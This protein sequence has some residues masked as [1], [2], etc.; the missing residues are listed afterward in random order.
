MGDRG[1]GDR[2]NHEQPHDDPPRPALPHPRHAAPGTFSPHISPLWSQ[3]GT[4]PPLGPIENCS[5]VTLVGLA[6]TM[7]RTMFATG[8]LLST[9]LLVGPPSAGAFHEDCAFV[10]SDPATW[11]VDAGW[12][13]ASWWEDTFGPA[14]ASAF[15]AGVTIQ[16]TIRSHSIPQGELCPQGPACVAFW[17]QMG[18]AAHQPDPGVLVGASCSTVFIGGQNLFPRTTVGQDS[19]LCQYFCSSASPECQVGDTVRV[20]IGLRLTYEW[21]APDNAHR[22]TSWIAVNRFGQQFLGS[23]KTCQYVSPLT[24]ALT[25]CP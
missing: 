24:Q 5:K 17:A 23:H 12:D 3:P 1:A 15:N 10:D 22:D 2:R 18:L 4:R 9:V 13:Y 21:E 11:S 25:A 7:P 16:C 14:P 20:A 19:I 6:N 8:L